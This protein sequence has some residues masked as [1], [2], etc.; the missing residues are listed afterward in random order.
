MLSCELGD[1]GDLGDLGDLGSSGDL[2]DL[3]NIAGLGDIFEGDQGDCPDMTISCD[4]ATSP[5]PTIP[6]RPPTT[7]SAARTGANPLVSQ[8]RRPLHGTKRSRSPSRDDGMVSDD[9][10]QRAR[11]RRRASSLVPLATARHDGRETQR[12]R[13]VS[14]AAAVQGPTDDAPTPDHAVTIQSPVD[15]PSVT[16]SSTPPSTAAAPATPAHTATTT[17]AISVASALEDLDAKQQLIDTLLSLVSAPNSTPTLATTDLAHAE[18]D[19]QSLCQEHRQLEELGRAYREQLD[20]AQNDLRDAELSLAESNK[21]ADQL[22]ALLGHDSQA[23]APGDDEGASVP[24]TASPRHMVLVDEI[25]AYTSKRDAARQLATALQHT[26]S[27]I[28]SR[29]SERTSRL[30]AARDEATYH[31]KTEA[32]KASVALLA[33]SDPAPVSDALD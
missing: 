21:R 23:K 10:H 13:G 33:N 6:C 24:A 20:K 7:A 11:G 5:R 15:T 12:Q 30:S 8:P 4:G 14:A 25:D 17:G 2:G 19:I 18:Q 29:L 28:A 32:F 31:R 22:S 26:T 3:G 16:A 1:M 27:S 9:Q